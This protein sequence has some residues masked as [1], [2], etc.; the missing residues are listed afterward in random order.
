MEQ[1]VIAKPYQFVPPHHGTVWPWLLQKWLPGHTR[2]RW[3]VEWPE[4]HSGARSPAR[5][6]KRK[7]NS[8]V[9]WPLVKPNEPRCS[10]STVMLYMRAGGIG[11]TTEALPVHRKALEVRR[12]LARGPTPDASA[13]A[14]VGRSLIAVGILLDKTGAGMR[15]GRLTRRRARCSEAWPNRVQKVT[16]S[17][18]SWLTASITPAPR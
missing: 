16:R 15:H 5:G 8:C 4:F 11:S 7:S 1:V 17:G 3:G 9:G 14:D 18:A 13:L 10:L 12:G 2:R 6:A